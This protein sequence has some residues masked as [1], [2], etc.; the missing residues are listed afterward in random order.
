MDQ[1]TVLLSSPVMIPAF[2]SVDCR[3]VCFHVINMTKMY[4]TKSI[5]WQI[6]TIPFKL[7]GAIRMYSFIQQGC[8]TM[9]KS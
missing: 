6:C 1:Y 7:L 5:L 8:I 3:F 4:S 2:A 9:I